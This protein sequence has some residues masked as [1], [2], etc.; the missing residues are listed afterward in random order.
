MNNFK[1]SILMELYGAGEKGLSIKQLSDRLGVNKKG[2]KKLE[3]ALTEM[4][5]H[6][7]I[8]YKKGSC[9]I[10]HPEFYFKAEVSRVSP[11]SGFIRSL[12]EA[13][14]EYFVRGRDLMGAIP[15][16]VVLARKT[17]EAEDGRSA[18]AMVMAVLEMNDSLLTGVISALR[19]R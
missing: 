4:K 2:A 15:G 3:N 5:A 12:D 18:E 14:T 13:P 10:R 9:W 7:D 17:A 6:G 19:S 11:K 8:A 16:D 1:I